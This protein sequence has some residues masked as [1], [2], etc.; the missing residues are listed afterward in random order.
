VLEKDFL[1]TLSLLKA[2]DPRIYDASV[3]LYAAPSHA[4]DETAAPKAKPEKPVYL[5]DHERRR[6]LTKGDQAFVTDDEDDEDE[7]AQQNPGAAGPAEG[8][9]NAEQAKLKQAFKEAASGRRH[10]QLRFAGPFCRKATHHL[11]VV[12]ATA[13]IGADADLDEEGGDLFTARK[14]TPAEEEERERGIW[15]AV[16][17]RPFFACEPAWFLLP[18]QRYRVPRIRTLAGRPRHAAGRGGEPQGAALGRTCAVPMALSRPLGPPGGRRPKTST[19]CGVTGL[20]PTSRRMTS[21]SAGWL[22]GFWLRL[23]WRWAQRSAP[24]RF[25]RDYITKHLWKRDAS[26][27]ASIDFQVRSAHQGGPPMPPHQNFLPSRVLAQ[28][29]V[30]DEAHVEETEEFERQFNF[31]FEEEGGTQVSTR[32]FR[33]TLAH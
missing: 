4:A 15:P 1:R 12:F 22:S 2:D 31:R 16:A 26:G 30:E 20:S 28:A 18:G 8:S 19:H 6:L 27:V 32:L 21:P 33:E 7:G 23:P 11:R 17:G 13:C 9:Y 3:N 10:R 29:D 5:K 25:L 14:L 24:R